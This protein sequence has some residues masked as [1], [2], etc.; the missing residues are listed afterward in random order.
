MLLGCIHPESRA[1]KHPGKAVLAE[2]WGNW[3]RP[4][5]SLA[6][7]D[8][9]SPYISRVRANVVASEDG[10]PAP[11]APQ[12]TIQDKDG[13]E[14][15]IENLGKQGIPLRL[16]DNDSRD[17]QGVHHRLLTV[18]VGTSEKSIPD[19]TKEV[20]A[21]LGS[22]L[23]GVQKVALPVG[24]ASAFT[25]E[26]GEGAKILYLVINGSERYEVEFVNTDDAASKAIMETFRARG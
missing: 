4:G 3:E 19:E 9:W 17:A 18:R 22:A 1:L 5:F 20:K 25:F 8:A 2:G 26:D 13:D 7:P 12:Y 24:D 6:A 15:L 23:K 11:T 16:Y 14:I 10:T 21:R